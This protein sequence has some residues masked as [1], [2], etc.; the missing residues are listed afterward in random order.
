[1]P[2]KTNENW[3]LEISVTNI[4][5]VLYS[6]FTPLEKNQEHL[7][8]NFPGPRKKLGPP[9]NFQVPS[10]CSPMEISRSW[11]NHDSTKK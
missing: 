10:A 2:V 9:G 5:M 3:Q 1:M 8:W 6:K 11:K 7:S 4:T